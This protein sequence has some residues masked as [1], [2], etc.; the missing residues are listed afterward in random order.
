MMLTLP[1]QQGRYILLEEI[2]RGGMAIVYAA[3]QVGPRGCTKEVAV[4]RLL[5]SW[6]HNHDFVTM[7]IDEARVL[8][9]LQHQN[10]VQIYELG[11][12]QGTYFIAMEYVAG[13]DLGLFLQTL[14]HRQIRLPERFAYF[15]SQEILKG[16]T[17]V[18]RQADEHGESLE[19]VHRDISPQNILLSIHGEVKV[20][21]FGIAKGT[22]R[23][24]TTLNGIKGKFAYMSPEQARG[25][26][27]D[28]RTDIFAV[29]ALLYEM[30]TGH[31]LFDAP[32]ELQILERIRQVRMPADWEKTL[33]PAVRAI[34]RTALAA[35]LR[36]RYPTAAGFLKELTAVV[37]THGWQTDGIE[38]AQYLDEIIPEQI[39][40][41]RQRSRNRSSIPPALLHRAR[42][43][44]GTRGYTAHAIRRRWGRAVVS[45]G[46]CCLSLLSA[47]AVQSDV[48]RT[49]QYLERR[50]P[51][52]A[53]PTPV[54]AAPSVTTADDH[55]VLPAPPPPPSLPIQRD[56]ARDRHAPR[57]GTLI[58]KVRPWGYVSIPGVVNRR[59]A[60]V[61]MAIS[62]GTYTVRVHG[63]GSKP[64][65]TRTRIVADRPTVCHATTTGTP[66]LRCR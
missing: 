50:L 31:P 46:L 49:V 42:E 14:N 35:E 22:H 19:L 6:S 18:H 20:A 24:A 32:N 12:D 27:L 65:E 59:E 11:L 26:A 66:Y 48:P 60:P 29:G 62:E 36:E 15:I 47:T 8:V 17:F 45:V 5:P 38:F 2:A 43:H 7:L 40:R 51:A 21:D 58:V 1:Y 30:L 41:L 64:V 61:Q 33:H 54:F 3:N 63:S 37:N 4:K 39:V 10:I 44:D 28:Q 34:L 13:I 52:L 16:L 57:A 23:S 9:Q 55:V 25:V 53:L 56:P